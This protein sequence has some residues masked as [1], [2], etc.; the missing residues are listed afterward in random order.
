MNPAPS[1]GGRLIEAMQRHPEIT[2]WLDLS[3]GLNPQPW[4]PPDIPLAVWHRLPEPNDGL[5]AAAKAYYQCDTLLPVAGSQM[6]IQ[7]LPQLRRQ[8]CGI[9]NVAVLD[10]SYQEHGYRWALSGH[11][12]ERFAS[13]PLDDLAWLDHIDVL[14][15]INPN[16]PTAQRWTPEQL[17]RW[18][19]H[20]AHR[21]G[22]LIV[23]EAFID[24]QPAHSVSSYAAHLNGLIVMRSVG[25]FF[26][27][28]GLRAGFVIT[29]PTLLDQL[30]QFIGPWALS[31][32]ARYI[33]QQALIDTQWQNEAKENL[34]NTS[35]KIFNMLLLK[36]FK[37]TR[38][39][40]LFIT[41]GTQNA[42]EIADKLEQQGILVRLFAEQ[43]QLRFG[44]PASPEQFLRLENALDRL[45]KRSI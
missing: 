43:R 3:T 32:P 31:G 45:A 16:N 10:F 26:G 9:A 27:L 12:V 21:G 1:H 33:L 38:K 22:W 20:L 6:A 14:V 2:D 18:H 39:T 36:G 30:A 41:A 37:E 23:D 42:E 44:L 19:T 35:R 8:L 25:K 7:A 4:Q 29:E 15:V 11:R 17:L 5:E 34:E 24:T 28:A 13:F 40:D